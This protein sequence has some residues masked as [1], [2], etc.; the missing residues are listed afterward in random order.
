MSIIGIGRGQIDESLHFQGTVA[1]GGSIGPGRVV[2]ATD[3]LGRKAEAFAEDFRSGS[4]R[5]G[6]C[7][8]HLAADAL[9]E[10]T[11]IAVSSSRSGAFYV[12]TFGGEARRLT[13]E[14]FEAE[15]RRVFPLGFERAEADKARRAAE[16]KARIQRETAEAEERRKAREA[17]AEINAEKAREIENNGQPDDGLPKLTGT[18]KQIA[19]ALS[20]RAAFARRRPG[21]AALKRGTT[22]KFW[23]ENHRGALYA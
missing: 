3:Y 8:W 13:E 4:R 2:R 6:S 10:L 7:V 20:I 11:G 5:S 16:E 21:D 18:P 1:A 15:L 14:E 17:L 22:A 12:S 9:Y 23:I 19:Y